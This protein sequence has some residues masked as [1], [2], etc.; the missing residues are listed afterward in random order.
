MQYSAVLQKTAAEFNASFYA[1]L[2]KSISVDVAVNSGRRA[3]IAKYPGGRDWSTPVLY[4]TT[5]SGRVLEFV[6]NPVQ[7]AVRAAELAKERAQREAGYREI[8]VA[9][10]EI[11]VRLRQVE[12]T[13]D[14]LTSAERLQLR[15]NSLQDR[16][17]PTQ[18]GEV[19]DRWKLTLDQIR[20]TELGDLQ[21]GLQ[22]STW[23]GA[24]WWQKL[25]SNSQQL[26]TNLL[27]SNFGFARDNFRDIKGSLT[28]G[29]GELRR[30][31]EDILR[32]SQK[33]SSDAMARFR[34]E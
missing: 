9:L 33:R 15:F 27:N 6:D 30:A 18:P 20:Q 17:F 2:D 21:T 3:L 5:R 24:S 19:A 23:E 31:M 16:D 13:L 12:S 29:I 28:E 26:S 32:D 22:G 14:A 34:V 1:A 4:M 10:G 8:I 25:L 11:A 7:A